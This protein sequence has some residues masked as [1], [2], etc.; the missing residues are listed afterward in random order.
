M[1]INQVFE[2]IDL[3]VWSLPPFCQDYDL[4]PRFSHH[5]CCVCVNFIYDFKINFV[6]QIFENLLMAISILLSE[7]LPEDCKGS[8]QPFNHNY[9]LAS[10]NTCVVCINFIH[11]WREHQLKIDS[12][13]QIFEK[14]LYGKFI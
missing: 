9:D 13:R 12:Q 5:P 2:H 14:L 8:L 1:E 10:C 7:F 3:M 6:H 11:N 4:R